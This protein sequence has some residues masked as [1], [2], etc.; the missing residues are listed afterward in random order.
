VSFV[1]AN[2][3]FDAISCGDKRNEGKSGVLQSIELASIFGGPI[4]S[5]CLSL[6][7]KA[8]FLDKP[9]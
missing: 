9:G 7:A 8:Y 4:P 2:S 3:L 5:Y 6:Q 1:V